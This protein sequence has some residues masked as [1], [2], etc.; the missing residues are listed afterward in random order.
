MRFSVSCLLSPIAARIIPTLNPSTFTITGTYSNGCLD[1]SGT[2]TLQL[3]I[4]E[5]AY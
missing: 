4:V 2:G 3:T 1:R 5:H